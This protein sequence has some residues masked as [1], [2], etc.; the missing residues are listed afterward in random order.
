MNERP[1]IFINVLLTALFAAAVFFLTTNGLPAMEA[2]FLPD[3][4]L[5][6]SPYV[7]L[8]RIFV[9][10]FGAAAA[11]SFLYPYS[12]R[13]RLLPRRCLAVPVSG[14]FFGLTLA[15]LFLAYTVLHTASAWARHDVLATRAFDLGIFAQAVWTTLHGQF[16]FSSIKGDICLLGD[17]VSPL[18]ALL[19][20]FYAAWESPKMLLL[21]QAAFAGANLV[22]IGEL[23]RRK[24]GDA[25]V[26]IL[27]ALLYFFYYPTRAAL[28]EDFHPE[29]LAE[30]FLIAAFIFL[31]KRRTI[32][33]LLCLITAVSAKENFW[34]I[35]FVFG[36]YA[37]L[38]QKRRFL[39]SI[40]MGFSVT[41]FLISIYWIV[42]HFSGQAY[43]Y[44]G[45]YSAVF[46]G[47]VS[48]ILKKFADGD[49]WEYVFK[50][51]LPFLFVPLL[52]PPTLLL[53]LPIL[54]QNVL[55]ENGAMRSFNYHYTTGL[56]PFVF[57]GCIYGLDRLQSLKRLRVL[58]LRSAVCLLL[59]VGLLRS[60]PS[61]L[62][63]IRDSRAKVTAHL[64]KI[65]ERLESVPPEL[66]VLTHNNFIPQLAN[67]FRVYQFDYR[68]SPT[69][70]EQAASLKVDR[71]IWDR[72][73]W[74]PGSHPPEQAREELLAAGYE[75]EFEE[76]GFAVF[77]RRS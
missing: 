74:E 67:R 1:V 17:H 12:G 8:M 51:L 18:L 29:V 52:H 15:F 27:F 68:L 5:H 30:P 69:K 16:L 57:L 77:R 33:F 63:Y 25:F 31:E 43:L 61:E 4:G 66:S 49:R 56:T 9:A 59:L 76:D 53:A 37:F 32:P 55:S 65:R 64:E 60:G 38:F 28:H 46:G 42:P 44:S 62:F 73:F 22:L 71:V 19:T 34:G 72:G 23:A 36:L 24:T 70:G 14:R 3:L 11:L 10:I 20:P 13:E 21:L 58:P 47:D 35:A 54:L 75:P 48:G 26:G 7:K 45:S 39:G 2:G 50:V 41:A 40:L 6:K